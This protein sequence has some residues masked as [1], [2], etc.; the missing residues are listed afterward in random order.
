MP[1]DGRASERQGRIS[2]RNQLIDGV[3][4]VQVLGQ[5]RLL[6]GAPSCISV[7]RCCQQPLTSA[8]SKWCPEQISPAL[9]PR[10]VAGANLTDATEGERHAGA[11]LIGAEHEPW[12]DQT[13]AP[14]L[15]WR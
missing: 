2:A 7:R 11:T 12:L 9:L 15:R 4:D 10:G 5:R 8:S 14:R 13:D 6:I 3:T 1:G